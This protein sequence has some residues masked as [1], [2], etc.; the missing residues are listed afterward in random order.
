MLSKRHFLTGIAALVAAGPAAAGEPWFFTRNGAAI[1]G[2][3]PVAYFTQG[4]PVR[5]KKE[6]AVMWKGA[7]WQ[8]SNAKHRVAFEMNPWAYAPQYGGYC[9]YAVSRG[10]TAK[11]EP[12]AW[13]IV[14]GK[15][16]LNYS[17]A[18]RSLWAADV[19]GNITKANANWPGVLNR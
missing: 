11:I 15:L 17:L 19:P 9:A 2:Y 10:Y 13:R 12:E 6:H 18:V 3:D 5:G 14:D 16:Y 7:V 8:F 4:K 1:S